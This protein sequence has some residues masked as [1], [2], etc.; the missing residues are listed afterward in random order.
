MS[1]PQTLISS[2]RCIV[3]DEIMQPTYILYAPSEHLHSTAKAPG[4]PAHPH[5]DAVVLDEVQ[6][7]G[8][9]QPPFHLRL[10]TSVFLLC[11]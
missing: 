10:A 9:T 4:A 7:I 3:D 5:P 11:D 2:P 8:R 6:Q 1:C